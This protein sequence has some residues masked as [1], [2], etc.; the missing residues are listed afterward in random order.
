MFAWIL[1][2][3]GKLVSQTPT[4]LNARLQAETAVLAA[5]RTKWVVPVATTAFDYTTP[6]INHRGH[7]NGT[8]RIR[9]WARVLRLLG[10]FCGSHF[11]NR[12]T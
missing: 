2:S 7:R 9:P 6:R 8:E 3:V 10:G 4:R 12:A 5:V 11:T 1:N